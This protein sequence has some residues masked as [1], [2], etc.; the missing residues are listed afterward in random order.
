[1]MKSITVLSLMLNGILLIAWTLRSPSSRAS[2][3]SS[4]TTTTIPL[5]S[6]SP[7]FSSQVAKEKALHWN[8]LHANDWEAMAAKLRAAG[9][10]EQRLADLLAPEVHKQA[11]QELTATFLQRFTGKLPFQP[12]VEWEAFAFH[13]DPDSIEQRHHKTMT[14]LF[15]PTDSE[16]DRFDEA[17]TGRLDTNQDPLAEFDAAMRDEIRK[18]RKERRAADDQWKAEEI[19]EDERGQ[20]LVELH[21]E[22]MRQLK[23]QF[24]ANEVND[25]ALRMSHYANLVRSA[26]GID[27]TPEEMQALTVL[28]E[29]KADSDASLAL[30]NI[31]TILGPDRYAQFLPH[32]ELRLRHVSTRDRTTALFD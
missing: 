12:A 16:R 30:P 8:D 20:R 18:L 15:G 19:G 7:Q 5:D 27:M 3:S 31:L 10:P 11:M 32:V 28:F 26:P 4:P 6:E 2:D 9:C 23:E 22:H 1:M 14:T 17:Y 13:Q 24:P 25:Y 29:E 21:T